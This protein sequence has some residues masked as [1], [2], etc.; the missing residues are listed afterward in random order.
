MKKFTLSVLLTFS[1]I[2]LF[3]QYP[4]AAG[5]EGSTAIKWDSTIFKAWATG[6]QIQRGLL[7]IDDPTVTY[8][9]YNHASFGTPSIVL[10]QAKE[11]SMDI[12]SLGDGGSAILTFDRPIVN[13]DGFDFAVFENGF[14][15]TFLE[16]AFVEVSS[17]GTHFVRFPSV[18]LTQE[19]TQIGGFDGLDP[20]K[21]NN[22]AGKYRQGYGTPFDLAEL[23][24]SVNLDINNVRFVKI[25]DVVGNILEPYCTYDSQGHKVNDPWPTPYYS[26]GFDL[27]AVGIIHAGT[28]Y[29]VSTFNDLTLGANSYWNGSDGTGGFN[30]GVAHF[31]NTYDNTYSSWNGFAYSSMNDTVTA[32]SANQ[33]SA[34]TR[35]ALETAG[36]DGDSTN[37][38]VC[39][40]ATDW[41]NNYASI[42]SVISF[43][44][45]NT[46][47][48][49]GFYVTN[50]TYTALSILN[51]DGYAKKF[52]GATGNDPDWYRLIV[53]GY[54]SQN[55]ITDSVIYYLAD[56]RFEDNSQDYVIK[57]WRWV[58]LSSLG[59]VAKLDFYVE[60]TD[61]GL[62]G[63][64]TPAYFCMDNLTVL[65][66]G[67]SGIKDNP[68]AKTDV[69]VYPNPFTDYCYLDNAKGCEISLFD[70]SGK[71]LWNQ[72]CT[73]ASFML[74]ASSLNPGYYLLKIV[75]GKEL[76][77]VKLIKK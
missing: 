14:S 73:S 76:K 72:K 6:C 21:I 20:T 51:G 13:G 34:Y 39:Y 18:S 61:A 52:G 32:G 11:S 41:M 8:G 17:D 67:T 66:G 48:V 30:N 25:V 22:L 24:D 40:V 69:R 46:H 65:Q 29:L 43:N 50:D 15:D 9:G 60:S 47:R 49:S 27:D 53:R 59:E 71:Q 44:N 55:T 58:D 36:V 7:Q 4:P 56:Y 42:P 3:A 2:L 12:A 31:S 35:D 28:P 62:Y 45:N 19:S 64:N 26:C 75:K 63:I 10:G 57:D 5:Q 23:A 37:Y 38:A 1:A 74:N 54:D 68:L 33:Y 77:T 70:I 16:L